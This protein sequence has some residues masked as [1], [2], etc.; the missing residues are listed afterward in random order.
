MRLTLDD[1]IVTSQPTSVNWSTARQ[2]GNDGLGAP[3]YGPYRTCNLGFDR[4]TV[5]EFN[6]W[7]RASRDGNPH[8]VRLPHPDRDRVDEYTNVYIYQ[9]SPRL[10]TRD[11]CRA[12]AA[13]VDILI[14]RISV[15]E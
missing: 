1:I 6:Q 9:F 14:T 11:I 15:T 2:L 3:V 8:D 7:G 10:N 13:G 5:N 12:A 4:L